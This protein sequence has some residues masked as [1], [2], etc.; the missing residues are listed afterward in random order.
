MVFWAKLNSECA[1]IVEIRQ[2]RLWGHNK[3]MRRK[4]ISFFLV[5]KEVIVTKQMNLLATE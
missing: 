4:I 3:F 1:E 5:T 2:P